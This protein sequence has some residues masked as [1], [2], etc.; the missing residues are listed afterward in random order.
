[1]SITTGVAWKP[2]DPLSLGLDHTWRGQDEGSYAEDAFGV[3]GYGRNSE[4]K[5]HRLGLTLNYKIADL[6]SIEVRQSLSVQD[7]WRI[8]EEGK[9]PIWDKYDASLVGK[10]STEYSLP[11]GTTLNVSVARTHRDATS[12]S[13][14]QREVWNISANLNRTF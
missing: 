6:V 10:A 4:R 13:E 12:I 2:F 7:K 1:M 14:R 8:T 3:E 9:T 11:D 5:D